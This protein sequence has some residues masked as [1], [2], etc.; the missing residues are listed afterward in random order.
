MKKIIDFFEEECLRLK[1][2]KSD[3]T[4]LFSV[5]A[6][7]D[8]RSAVFLTDHH[9]SHLKKY[10]QIDYKKPDLFVFSGLGNEGHEMRKKLSEGDILPVVLRDDGITKISGVRYQDLNVKSGVELNDI[11]PKYVDIDHVKSCVPTGAQAFIFDLL[12]EGLGE[13]AYYDKHTIL[14]FEHEN[15]DV[16]NKIIMKAEM[17]TDYLC[18][19]REGMASGGCGKSIIQWIYEDNR[20][21]DKFQEEFNPKNLFLFEDF[22]LGLFE[23]IN[24]KD[25]LG[26]HQPKYFNYPAEEK[27]S[28]LHSRAVCYRKRTV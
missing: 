25:S 4:V 19:L 20:H 15:I 28:D 7:V 24:E 23:E 9:I 14:Y 6:G 17:K 11:N 18:A 26:Y 16:F 22:T 27:G 2:I 13:D 12:I 21:N 10:N 8:F 5:S 1:D 3:S